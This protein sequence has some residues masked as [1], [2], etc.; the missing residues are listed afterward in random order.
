MTKMADSYPL[1]LGPERLMAHMRV[2]CKELPRRRSA[3]E[4]ERKAGEYAASTMERIGIGGVTAQAFKGIPTLGLP[5]VITALI[6]LAAVFAGWFG[7]FVGMLLAGALLCFSSFTFFQLLSCRPPLFHSLIERWESR[8]VFATIPPKGEPTRRIVLVG[9]LDANKQRFIFPPPFPALMKAMQSS[10]IVAP[11][12]AGF[13]FIVSAFTGFDLRWVWAACAVFLVGL[14]LLLLIDEAQPVIEGAN[15]NATAM[16][17]LLGIGEAL[18]EQP[19]ENTELTL[20]FTGCEEVGNHGLIA[21]LDQ[22]HP[23]VADTYWI[24]VEMVGT[25]GV[26]YATKHGVSYLTEYRPTSDILGFAE[27]TA[28]AESDLG[29]SGK[30]MLIL[31]EVAPLRRYGYSALC[32]VGYDK[33]G[34]LP[35]W[36][37]VSDN[38]ENIESETLSRAAR[39]AWS[40]VRAIDK[41]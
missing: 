19:L 2:I 4:G 32:L 36:H 26:A 27:R 9:H 23:P 24:D 41:G 31:E 21:Y 25:G 28:A 39:F 22:Y 3:G 17:V 7:G 11:A 30:D 10:V 33:N 12:L 15:D 5:A 38:L 13:S 16:S 20:L 35:N 37:R 8:N 29:V 40:L 1:S 18:R 6:G 14:L 34:N